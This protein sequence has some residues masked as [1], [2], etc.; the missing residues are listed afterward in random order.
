MNSTTCTELKRSLEADDLEAV[1]RLLELHPGGLDDLVTKPDGGVL[2]LLAA[3]RSGGMA[4]LLLGQGLTVAQVSECWAQ[5]FGLNRFSPEVAEHFIRCGA[6]ITPHAAAGLG[7][8]ERLRQLLDQQPG[9]VHAKGGD[10]GRP[11]HFSRDLAT[12]RLLVE[13]GAK[14]DARDDDHDST[15]AQWRIGEAHEVTRFLIGQGARSDIFMAAGLGDLELAQRLVLENPRCT[16]YRI[17]N[18]SGPFPGIGAR[19]GGGTIYQW[20]L[21]FNQSPQEIAHHRGHRDVFDFLM[22]QT[23][24]RQRLLV[25]CMLA[26]RGLAQE[27][28]AS[29]PGLVDTLDDEDRALL[30]K[31]CWETNLNREAVRLMLDLGFPIA[32]P[33]Y[34]HGFQALHN[35]AWCGDAELVELLLRRGHPVDRRDPRF[36]STALGYAIHSCVTARC[37]PEGDFQRV[38]Q[39]LLE[40]GTPL[41]P[42]QSPSGNEG[43][44]AV[45]QTHRKTHP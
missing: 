9:L 11:L 3:V 45:I 26:N 23:P 13:R 5:G 8:I 34:N 32:V 30:A 38:V 1:T 21:G 19:G 25:A 12:A 29:S 18:N 37:H 33:E 22:S 39:L 16:T 28:A 42:S 27:I 35:A 41:D 2:R 44:D 10:G 40:A 20:T 4:D 31:C 14:L 17:G 43:I 36:Q 15:A 7:L 6:T 24:P